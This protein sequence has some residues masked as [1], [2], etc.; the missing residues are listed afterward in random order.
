MNGKLALAVFCMA[1]GFLLPL[2]VLFLI[3]FLWEDG[4]K[5]AITKEE[6]IESVIN[7]YSVDTL[8]DYQ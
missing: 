4:V 5:D 3:L 7:E 8:R 6:K 2:G 1:T